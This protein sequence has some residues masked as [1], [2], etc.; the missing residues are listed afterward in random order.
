MTPRSGVA[1]GGVESWLLKLARAEQHLANLGTEIGIPK[2]RNPCPVGERLNVDGEYEYHLQVPGKVTDIVPIVVGELL[3]N[4]RS[5]LDHMVC[6]MIPGD[7]KG[8]AQFPIFDTDPNELDPATGKYADPNAHALWKRHTRG[9]P[10]PAKT[11]LAQLQPHE[12]ARQTGKPPQHHT[13]SILS[14]LQNADK[15]RQLLFTEPCL[16]QTMV[17]PN[18]VQPFGYTPGLKN[19]AVIYEHPTKVDVK[20]E[21]EVRIPLGIGDGF[22]YQY[23]LV[24]DM[25][26]D[27]VA[28]E[29]LPGL[30]PFLP[31]T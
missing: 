16:F 1:L 10:D 26:L 4:V 30:N 29:V 18:G 2:G 14:R 17:Y 19:G 15:H 23:P 24:F 5:A 20:A 12:A 8:R 3:F 7:D 31:A 25:I 11:V 6:A 22:G 28:N 27:T 21:G 9:V 13:L